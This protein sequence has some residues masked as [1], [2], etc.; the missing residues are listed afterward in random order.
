MTNDRGEIVVLDSAGYGPVTIAQS[1]SLVA[2]AGVYAGITVPVSG[3]GITISPGTYDVTLR[4]LTLTDLA[5][6]GNGIRAYHNGSLTLERIAVEGASISIYMTTPS[7]ARIDWRDIV[8]KNG[9]QGIYVTN[10][11]GNM[12]NVFADGFTSV[13]IGISNGSMVTVTNA[14]VSNATGNGYTAIV[15]SASGGA[16]TRMTVVDSH[17]TNVFGG[18]AA[19]DFGGTVYVQATGNTIIGASGSALSASNPGAK[20]IAS[21]NSV[22]RSNIGL[23]GNAGGTLVT[24]FDNSVTLN[25]ADSSGSISSA[26]YQ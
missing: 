12:T 23:T 5:G 18:I 4:G 3:N 1:V 6:S 11:S 10:V 14:H 8:V 22:T 13:P 15:A 9:S 21:R 25:T 16:L 20:L 7:S 19:A 24:F 26:S 17:M 2:P